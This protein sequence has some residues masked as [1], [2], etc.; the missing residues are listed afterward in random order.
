MDKDSVP[1]LPGWK[2][3][4]IQD[5][6]ICE[7]G[8]HMLYVSVELPDV[9]AT[10]LRRDIMKTEGLA[11]SIPPAIYSEVQKAYAGLQE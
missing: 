5:W 8:G 2:Q 7:G 11:D 1:E 6:R 4:D 3:V 10:T 9:S